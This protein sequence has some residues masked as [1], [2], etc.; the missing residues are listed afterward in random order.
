MDTLLACGKY[1]EMQKALPARRWQFVQW[2]MPCICGST[3]TVM[4][5]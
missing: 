5:A 2:Q 4:E 3:S 1:N